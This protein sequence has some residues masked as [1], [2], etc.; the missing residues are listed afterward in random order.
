MERK[1]KNVICSL[2][3]QFIM[4]EFSAVLKMVIS[5]F[6]NIFFYKLSSSLKR[7]YKTVFIYLTML[8]HNEL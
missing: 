5:D 6:V 4:L 2:F 3:F 8:K 7:T 1:T